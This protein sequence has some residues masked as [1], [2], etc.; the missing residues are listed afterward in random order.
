MQFHL[1]MTDTMIADWL[2]RYHGCLPETSLCVQNPEQITERLSERLRQL[3]KIADQVYSS[4][5]KMNNIS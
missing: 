4:W 3:N 1:E 5:L 2:E